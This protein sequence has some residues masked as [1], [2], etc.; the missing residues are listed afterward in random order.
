MINNQE[1]PKAVGYARVSSKDQEDTGYSLPAQEKLLHDYAERNGYELVKVFAIQESAAGKIQRKIFHEMMAHVTKTKI[2]T[3]FVETTDRLT[4]NFADVPVIDNWIL[5]DENHKIHL[6]KENC[7]LHKD[8]KSHEW[9]MWRVKVATAEYYIRLLSENVKKGQKE[10]LSQGW[11]PTKPPLGYKTIGEKGHKIH[12]IDEEKSPLI[13][14]MFDL[15]ASGQYSTKKLCDVMYEQGFRSRTGHKVSH[16]RIH[17]LVG[18]PFYYGMNRWKNQITKGNHEPL[19]SKE[20]YQRVQDRLHSYGAPRTRKHNSLFKSVFRCVECNGTITWE[21]QKGHWYGHCNHY[22]NCSQRD[23]VKQE[24]IDIQIAESIVAVTMKDERVERML[25]WIQEALKEGHA[26][27]ITFRETASSELERQYQIATQ[28]IDKLYDDKIDNRISREF[29]DKK[30]EQYKKEQDNVLDS[31]NRHRNASLKYFEMGITVLEVA[32]QARAIYLN[33]RRTVEQKRM[34]FSFLFSN[35]K[36]NGKN[37][38]ISYQKPFQLILDTV[39]EA[40]SEKNTKKN[41]FEPPKEPVDKGKTPASADAHPI[42][43]R[44]VYDV[45]TFFQTSNEHFFIPNLQTCVSK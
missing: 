1:L 26:D 20:L 11:L 40:L 9:F 25:S 16:A 24:N 3:V 17:Q 30:L 18:D 45:R 23:W 39:S 19:I 27:E 36:I 5:A 33:P 13:K 7:I 41:T 2:N 32:K 42:W 34:L 21:I 35:P 14:K 22:K 4:R 38:E 31:L 37:V 12:V 43:L 8:S 15:Y 28:R 6:V 44:V 10:K 29:Y